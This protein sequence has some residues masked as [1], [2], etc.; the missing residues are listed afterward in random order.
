MFNM[1]SY[2]MFVSYTYDLIHPAPTRLC[3]GQFIMDEKISNLQVMDQMVK[4]NNIGICLSTTLINADLTSQGIVVGFGVSESIGKDAEFQ[5][6]SGW[7]GD[8]MFL[9]FAVKRS[10]FEKTKQFL[11]NS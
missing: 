5:I 2:S 9:C 4:D 7:P 8:Y 6:N 3:K 1:W 10:E 11:L